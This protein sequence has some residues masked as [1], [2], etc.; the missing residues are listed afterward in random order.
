MRNKWKC[1]ILLGESCLKISFSCGRPNSE[2]VHFWNYFSLRSVKIVIILSFDLNEVS[3]GKTRIVPSQW[4]KILDFSCKR[5][6]IVSHKESVLLHRK[7]AQFWAHFLQNGS[8]W[9]QNCSIE[10]IGKIIISCGFIFTL[11]K[12]KVIKSA[13]SKRCW[14]N[15]LINL[16]TVKDLPSCNRY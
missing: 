3:E 16:G 5:R 2:D 10:F 13:V 15:K 11:I 9:P 6:L 8:F 7:T 4:A 14:K 12:T 1:E